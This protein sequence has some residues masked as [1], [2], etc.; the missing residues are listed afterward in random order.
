MIEE[1]KSV[2][3]KEESS[4]VKVDGSVLNIMAD[5]LEEQKKTNKLLKQLVDGLTAPKE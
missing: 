5:I 4:H 3:S 1:I 2:K